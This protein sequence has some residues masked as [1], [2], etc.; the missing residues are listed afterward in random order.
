MLTA[1]DEQ[2]VHQTTETFANVVTSDPSWTERAYGCA[3]TKSGSIALHWGLGKYT[4]RNVMDGF[5]GISTGRAQRQI[6]FSRRLD[7]NPLDTV[8]GPFRY[9]VIE[10]LKT[11]RM[12]L[13]PTE[14]QPIACDIVQH[15]IIGPWLEDRSY[16]QRAFRRV[17]DEMRYI[18]PTT[19]TGWIEYEGQRFD[20]SEGDNFG[21]RDHSWGVKQNTG[22]AAPEIG[23]RARMPPGL[24]FRMTWLPAVLERPDGG[25]YRVHL[26]GW[27]A[28]SA[29]GTQTVNESQIFDG[30]NGAV[31]ARATINRM[32]FDPANREPLGGQLV[33]IMEDG[34]E[35]PFH[36][37][38]AAEPRVGLGLGLYHGYRGHYHGEARGK[39]F[40]EGEH[41]LNTG[42]PETSREIHQ[43]RDIL[44]RVTDPV[45]G[46]TGWG[47]INTEIV[48][49]WPEL[50]LD[51]SPWR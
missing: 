20:L 5:V 2:F 40:V 21:F 48:G 7:P 49:A 29:R 32:T 26:F 50:G 36:I 34:S 14:H 30:P 3:I 15:A 10:P 27:E 24:K 46:G 25:S 12:I 9:E 38:V 11:S 39:L 6:R 47:I 37:E 33:L 43:L 23:D 44:V 41:V 45:G 28:E 51:D 19:T 18:M 31:H 42:D 35:R 22:P 16:V 17:Q 8:V 13:E 4:N 1:A